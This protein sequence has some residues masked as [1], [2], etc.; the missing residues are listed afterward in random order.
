MLCLM[1]KLF[2]FI[3]PVLFLCVGLCARAEREL[4]EAEQKLENMATAFEDVA[5]ALATVQDVKDA[6]FVASRVAVDFLMLRDLHAAMGAMKNNADV[7]AEYA[8]SF[9]QRCTKARESAVACIAALQQCDYLGSAALPAATSLAALMKEP[10]PAN[11]MAEAAMELKVN[12]MEM[13]V[14]LLDEVE[15]AESAET[16]ANLVGYALAH[17]EIL[18]AFAQEYEAH[19]MHPD[20]AVYF[21]RRVE[22]SHVDFANMAAELRDC[23]YFNCEALRRVFVTEELPE[24]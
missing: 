18:E 22:D 4:T 2:R 1:L 7:S 5:E 14:L 21:A 10:Q 23:Q 12:N 16:V 3:L 8:Q 24:D 6:D 15:D 9:V 19:P 17:G 20:S 13:I 11:V